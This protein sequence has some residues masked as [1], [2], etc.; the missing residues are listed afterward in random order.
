MGKHGGT[1]PVCHNADAMEP[2]QIPKDFNGELYLFLH[3]DV[4]KAGMDPLWHY[5]HHGYKE[6][7][8]AAPAGLQP[9]GWSYLNI[10]DKQF[11]DNFIRQADRCYGWL[12]SLHVQPYHHILDFGCGEFIMD[13]GLVLRY[14]C[15][16]TG[17]DIR[18]H[19]Q[20]HKARNMAQLGLSTF[21]DDLKLAT[22]MPGQDL[23]SIGKFDVIV[24]WSVF[25]HIRR[26]L[27]DDI[28]AN[29]RDILNENGMVIIQ[30][31]PLYFSPF[32]SHLDRIVKE[33]WAH[34]LYS[35]EQIINRVQSTPASETLDL[36]LSE[37]SYDFIK[38][39]LCKEFLELNMMGP[40]ELIRLFERN[41]FDI[42][43]EERKKTDL[44]VPEKLTG[45]FLLEDLLTTEIVIFCKSK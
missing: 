44:A 28:V 39:Y 7:R 19:F 33:P 32:G 3:P 12:K 41:G 14:G 5:T 13:L 45:R 4:R 35:K 25:E 34:L 9:N 20:F 26:E 31:D 42:M 27:I 10:T 18:D 2:T 16:V 30:I 15:H 21:P 1:E 40:N 23:R 17:I 11:L 6:G 24:S 8:N 38:E 29:F 36:P 43:K 22:I 37:Q